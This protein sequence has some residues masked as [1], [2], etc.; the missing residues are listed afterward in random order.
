MMQQKL[1]IMPTTVVWLSLVIAVDFYGLGTTQ[2]FMAGGSN[3][4]LKVKYRLRIIY[5]GEMTG[6]LC[7]L[8]WA[9]LSVR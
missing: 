7:R 1:S 9:M 6:R 3:S 5:E 2:P 4:A 8:D